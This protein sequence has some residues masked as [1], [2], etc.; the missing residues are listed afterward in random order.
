[1]KTGRGTLAGSVA[2]VNVGQRA[3]GGGVIGGRVTADSW[4][5]TGHVWGYRS[6]AGERRVGQELRS[7]GVRNGALG[8]VVCKVGLGGELRRCRRQKTAGREGFSNFFDGSYVNQYGLGD[9]GSLPTGMGRSCYPFAGR[10]LGGHLA[11]RNFLDD[12][13]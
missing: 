13:K 1:M 9:C 5:R 10:D 12:G 2:G 11:D 7:D 6:G 3:A 4:R 8:D